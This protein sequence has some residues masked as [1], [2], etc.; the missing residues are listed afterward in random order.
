MIHF[1]QIR[2][3]IRQIEAGKGQQGMQEISANVFLSVFSCLSKSSRQAVAWK[4][5]I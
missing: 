4:F 1:L 3:E 2:Q 5:L